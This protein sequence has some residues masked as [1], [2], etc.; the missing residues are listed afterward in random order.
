M[1]NSSNATRQ[2]RFAARLE[3]GMVGGYFAVE[4]PARISQAIG[5]RGPIPVKATINNVAEFMASLSPAGGGRHRLRL[6]ARVR[7][8]ARAKSGDSVKVQIA[9]LDQPLKVVIPNDLKNALRSEG[10]LEF[11]ETFAPGKQNH[12]IGWIEQS[13]QPETREKR[14]QFTVEVTHMRH[15]KRIAQEARRKRFKE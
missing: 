14:I 8:E 1:S 13:V 4:V 9:V 12:I 15:E 6:N 11:F 2:F 7:E 3:H 5:K 10:A